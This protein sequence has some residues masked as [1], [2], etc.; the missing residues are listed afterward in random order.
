MCRLW[1]EDVVFAQN[2]GFDT[3]IVALATTDFSVESYLLQ[4]WT[5][6]GYS[7]YRPRL[8]SGDR[9][10]VAVLD[11]VGGGCCCGE[12]AE[13]FA[14]WTFGR[15]WLNADCLCIEGRTSGC[16]SR[17][18]SLWAT[19]DLT[20][21]GRVWLK[22]FETPCYWLSCRKCFSTLRDGLFCYKYK[23]LNKWCCGM[24]WCVS[25]VLR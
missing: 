10:A 8:W 6:P 19:E 11:S 14:E 9:W 24:W 18:F 5:Q 7:A 12:R 3:F 1:R 16:Q 20:C 23:I 25:P 22:C 17:D 13:T 15:R 2:T 4:N 21:W